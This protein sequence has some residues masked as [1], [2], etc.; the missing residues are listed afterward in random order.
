MKIFVEEL[1][2]AGGGDARQLIKKTRLSARR[3]KSVTK[4]G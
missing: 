2:G 4:S 1:V 3:T